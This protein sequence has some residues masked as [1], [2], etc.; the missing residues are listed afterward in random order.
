MNLQDRLEAMFISEPNS[1]CWLWLGHL[2]K[3]GYGTLGVKI[4]GRWK[5][6]HAHRVSY[7]TFVGP[8]Q[9]GSDIDHKCRQRCC[10]NP[11][12][13]EPVSRSEN[14]SRSPLMGRQIHKSHCPQGH[15]YS[16]I[17]SR[18]QRVCRQC[19]LASANRYYHRQR[20]S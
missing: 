13:M 1:G 3:N 15:Q 9:E 11:D 7:E 17:N 14:L 2:K 6:Q 20:K 19:G 12:H 18:G 16:G 5:T 10:V 8:I 4:D